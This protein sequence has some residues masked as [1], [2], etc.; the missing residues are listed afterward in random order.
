MFLRYAAASCEKRHLSP[1][2]QI[3]L[4]NA[5]HRDSPTPER[6]FAFFSYLLFIFVLLLL[7]SSS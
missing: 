3:P 4:A 7:F 5:L 1:N 2:V 6:F